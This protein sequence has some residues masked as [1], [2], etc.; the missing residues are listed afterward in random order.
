MSRPDDSRPKSTRMTRSR[1]QLS[2]PGAWDLLAKA[3]RG[4]DYALCSSGMRMVAHPERPVGHIFQTGP[5]KNVF[6]SCRKI[7]HAGSS[8]RTA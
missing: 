5:F 8:G 6:N 7:G 3:H 4:R 1:L 2:L